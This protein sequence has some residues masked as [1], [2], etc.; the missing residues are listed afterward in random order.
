LYKL[1][2]AALW[3][4]FFAFVWIG[5]VWAEQV[6]L[7][8]TDSANSVTGELLDFDGDLYRIETKYGVLTVNADHVTCIS[9]AC[10]SLD[11][12]DQSFR[13]SGLEGIHDIL[14]PALIQ[15]FGQ[16]KDYSVRRSGDGKDIIQFEMTDQ[17][18]RRVGVIELAPMA[19]AGAFE[20]LINGGSEIVLSRREMVEGE[21]QAAMEN[22][23][24]DFLT[25]TRS[26]VFALDAVVPVVRLR[27]PVRAISIPDLRLVLSQGI[28]NW[29]DLGGIDT[30]ILL[31]EPTEN[32]G[33]RQPARAALGLEEGS[34]VS[35]S[36]AV[37][38]VKDLA[39]SPFSMLGQGQSLTLSGSC[40]YASTATRRSIKTEDYPLTM[41]LYLYTPGRRLPP[42]AR[43]FIA[44]TKT[45]SAQTIIR[46]SGL[47]DQLLEE[48]KI[49]EQGVRFLN[50][51][52]VI[53]PDL[54]VSVARRM[55]GVLEGKSRLTVSFRF[56]D[57]STQL[58][59]QSKSNVRLLARAIKAGQFAE[60][61]LLFVGFS[62]GVGSG[63]AN[64]AISLKRA[65]TVRAEVELIADRTALARVDMQT[66]AFGE[67]M[68]MACDD[69]DLGRHVNRRVEVWVR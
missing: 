63:T 32:S 44:F 33:L 16:R 24:G 64:L 43:D 53:E 30:P 34:T 1:K 59:A 8:G 62:D 42:L 5:S 22:H 68:P 31:R 2:S 52:R 20:D 65:E 47:V 23:I 38:D 66:D 67:A 35:D 15:A 37:K 60:R 69:S 21:R 51:I 10:P 46:R 48:I 11:A 50:A 28:T 56:E 45:V 40:G 3:A 36:E 39:L 55:V 61:E 41:P 13:I 18:G 14:L 17:T 7:Q 4:A 19:S 27:N 49:N 26:S 29:A 54:G 12:I 57:G 9:E 25:P 58:N 6:T